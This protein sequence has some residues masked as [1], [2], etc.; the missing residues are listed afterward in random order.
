MFHRLNAFIV[1]QQLQQGS[2]GSDSALRDWTVNSE[3][4]HLNTAMN[5]N[6]GLNAALSPMNPLCVG[7]L[8]E[9]GGH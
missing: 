4:D 9:N 1:K 3:A 7:M 8:C 6:T 5:R 2:N